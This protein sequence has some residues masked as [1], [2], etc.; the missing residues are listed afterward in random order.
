MKTVLVATSA[1]RHADTETALRRQLFDALVLEQLSRSFAAQ[2]E[3]EGRHADAVMHRRASLRGARIARGTNKLLSQFANVPCE[4]TDDK[5][6]RGP[7]TLHE[8]LENWA[9]Y[10]R[11]GRTYETTITGIIC[12]SMRRWHMGDESGALTQSDIDEM[13]GELVHRALL[14]LNGYQRELLTL[15]YR[16]RMPPEIICRKMG[17]KPRPVSV[18]DLA[19][20]RAEDEVE[21]HLSAMM[22]SGVR[23]R[24]GDCR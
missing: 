12:E 23:V 13:D 11:G 19:R 20:H 5:P 21:K 22:E 4:T 9:R 15:L 8:R 3:Q 14:R 6:R 18:F 7:K 24:I 2:A 10:M 17:I 16:W 1:T